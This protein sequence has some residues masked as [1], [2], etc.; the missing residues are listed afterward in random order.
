MGCLKLTYRSENPTLKVVHSIFSNEEKSSAGLYRYGF[1][2]MEKDDEAKGEGNSYTTPFRQYDP[3]LG[4]WFSTDPVIHHSMS[5]YCAFDNNPIYFAD[6]L[7][8][9]SE[10]GDEDGPE[11]GYVPKE[12]T[13]YGTDAEGDFQITV[14]PN[15]KTKAKIAEQAEIARGGQMIADYNMYMIEWESRNID[16]QGGDLWGPPRTGSVMAWTTPR[17]P[18]VSKNW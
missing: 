4:R 15:E 10:G 7:G 6:P 5:A 9:D 12:Q 3:R 2:G 1:N 14:S 16:F 13:T 18:N 17:T 11:G 8:A